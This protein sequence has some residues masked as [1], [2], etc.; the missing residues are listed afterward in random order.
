MLFLDYF[1]TPQPCNGVPVTKTFPF[2]VCK[3]VVLK[4]IWKNNVDYK[5]YLVWLGGKFY[6]Y[7]S[8]IISILRLIYSYPLYTFAIYSS[9]IIKN[10]FPSEENMLNVVY[11]PGCL[12][13]ALFADWFAGGNLLHYRVN[14][15]WGRWHLDAIWLVSWRRLASPTTVGSS[16]ITRLKL[17]W[18]WYWSRLTWRLLIFEIADYIIEQAANQCHVGEFQRRY[19]IDASIRAFLPDDWSVSS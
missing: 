10:I 12:I 13:F 16:D 1:I 15:P 17:V 19:K 11:L 3:I 4:S 7:W 9:A 8:C 5:I 2:S 14:A 18:S 6:W